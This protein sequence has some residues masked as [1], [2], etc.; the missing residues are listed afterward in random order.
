MRIRDQVSVSVSG[1]LLQD[2]LQHL[3]EL[4]DRLESSGCDSVQLGILTDRCEGETE[5]LVLNFMREETT[6]E[7]RYREAMEFEVAERRFKDTV[8]DCIEGMR[9]MFGGN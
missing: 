6:K 5:C 9:Q 3:N 8:K 4:A 2:Q 1:M 7:T